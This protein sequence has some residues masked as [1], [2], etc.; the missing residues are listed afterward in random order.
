MPPTSA[1]TRFIKQGLARGVNVASMIAAPAERRAAPK[2]P[3]RSIARHP[4]RDPPDPSLAR[5]RHPRPLDPR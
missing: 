4:D 3:Q 1:L 2:R 5:G